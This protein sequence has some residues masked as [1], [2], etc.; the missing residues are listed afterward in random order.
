MK[1]LAIIIFLNILLHAQNGH[2]SGTVLS[3]LSEP[4][5]GANIYLKE[6]NT[7][8]MTD[9][10]GS[11]SI[12]GLYPGSYTI[13]ISY[14]GY[15]RITMTYV[16]TSDEDNQN[17]LDKLGLQDIDEDNISYGEKFS[18]VIFKLEPDAVALRQV[19][20]TGHELDK[21][22]SDISKQT[23]FAPS[24]IRESYMTVGASVDAVS[25]K[26]IKMSPALN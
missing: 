24:K 3:E 12:D 13:N 9:M 16:I 10:E 17:Y 11:F 21:S 6:T 20:V 18:D 8:A 23:I 14:I 7:G 2:I 1:Q 25:I 5:A 19:N 4:L 15:K 22:L 26:D